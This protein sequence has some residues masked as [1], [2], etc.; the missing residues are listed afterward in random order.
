VYLHRLN[1]NLAALWEIARAHQTK[2][3]QVRG[4]QIAD[5]ATQNI[6]QAGDR[7]LFQHSAN[8]NRPTKLSAPFLGPF[9]VLDQYQC[10][11]DVQVRHLTTVFGQ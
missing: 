2:L 9:E 6:F 8:R 10:K 11:N 1:A 7:V 4:D 5:P 3:R